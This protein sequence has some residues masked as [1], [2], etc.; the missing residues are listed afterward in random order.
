MKKKKAEPEYSDQF[1]SFPRGNHCIDELRAW[2]IYEY[3]RESKT[4]LGLVEKHKNGF[5]CPDLGDALG[6]IKDLSVPFYQIVKSMGR[7]PSFSKPWL[8]LN[9]ALR[10]KIIAGCRIPA[11][12]IAPESVIRDCLGDH[13]ALGW[14]QDIT[15]NLFFGTSEP[16]RLIPLLLNASLTK[17]EIINEINLFFEKNLNM[18]GCRGKGATSKN[19]LS[20]SLRALAVLRLISKRSQSQ[21]RNISASIDDPLIPK[22]GAVRTLRAQISKAQITFR[23]M[24]ALGADYKLEDEMVSYA[25]YKR[26]HSRGGPRNS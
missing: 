17:I 5:V 14:G 18:V 24:F 19:K 3:A 7:W 26:H 9:P 13:P 16:L 23:E 20:H 10:K 21:A 8:E 11:V 25:Q 2:T 4:L 6:I 22:C 1:D 12:S 15:S